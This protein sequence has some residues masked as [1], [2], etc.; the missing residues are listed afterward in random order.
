[1]A[2]ATY[3]VTKRGPRGEPLEIQCVAHPNCGWR[4]Q[5]EGPKRDDNPIFVAQFRDHVANAG[6]AKSVFGHKRRSRL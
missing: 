3:T 2:E 4:M 1:M 6:P 5:S